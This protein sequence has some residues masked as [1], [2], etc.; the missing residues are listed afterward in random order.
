ME[1]FDSHC[2]LDAKE[3]ADDRA[4]VIERA[5]TAGVRYLVV[6]GSGYG[7][8]DSD[9]AVDVARA[10][11]DVWATVGV[12]PHD[13][14]Q[15]TPK[16]WAHLRDLARDEKVV[17]WG[18]IGLDYHYDRSPRPV[19]NQVFIEQ[20]EIALE[21]DLPVS[22]H[23][24]EAATDTLVHLRDFKARYDERLR[25]IWHCFTENVDTAEEAV[26]LGFYISIPGIVT[27]PKGQNVRDVVG[28]IPLERLVIETDSPF[29]APVPHRGK[30]NEPSW[31][32]ETARTLAEIKGVT[33][34]EVAAATTA[35]ALAGYEIES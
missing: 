35:N 5:R 17:A 32:V 34:D 10:H 18:E 23:V 31:V 14:A 33:L 16:T 19:Q 2:H 12:H 1:L 24:R 13:A 27:F 15:A 30:R 4:E 28:R 22:L 26:D 20:L 11:T 6:I 3:F 7:A 21:L 25:G 8:G 29:L 9:S